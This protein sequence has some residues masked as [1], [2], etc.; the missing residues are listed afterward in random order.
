MLG[1]ANL[2]EGP[3]SARP[4][5]QRLERARRPDGEPLRA[6]R[7]PSGS[8]SGSGGGG[9]GRAGPARGRHRDRRL[10]RLPGRRLRR[11]RHQADGRPAQPVRHR[12]DPA[13]RTPRARWRGPSPTRP[14]CWARW[15][16]APPARRPPPAAGLPDNYTRYLKAGGLEGARLGSGGRASESANPAT[17]AELDAAV[18]PAARERGPRVIDPVD[19]PDAVKIFEG[20]EYVALR[21]EFKR[22]PQRLPGH[23]CP[24]TTP[25]QPGRADR[26]QQ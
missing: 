1:K 16:A 11:G 19:L 9:G 14:R 4:F 25:E 12:A 26:L 5:Q 10:D 18:A 8:S 17:L 6:R 24:A 22:R 21:H 15:P 7:Y 2:S 13:P 23:A 3:T 20:P